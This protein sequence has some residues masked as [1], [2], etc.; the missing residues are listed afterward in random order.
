VGGSIEQD[1]V[2]T[3]V[4]KALYLEGIRN[5]SLAKVADLQSLPFAAQN[6]GRSIDVVIAV[7]LV[8]NDPSG[9][10]TSALSTALMQMGITGR[11]PIIPG[12]LNAASLL[13]GKALLPAA[14]ENWAKSV[15]SIL[16]IRKNP[17]LEFQPAPEPEIPQPIVLTPAVDDITVLM[18]ALRESFKV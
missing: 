2:A 10:L 1:F 15:V 6:L 14:A 7:A 13:E 12:L 8:P 16:D 3:T 17:G 5:A 11:S 9:S 4:N 18:E